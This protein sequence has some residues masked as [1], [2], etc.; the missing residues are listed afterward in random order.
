MDDELIARDA[1]CEL[2]GSCA[3]VKP[4]LVHLKREHGRALTVQQC[5]DRIAMDSHVWLAEHNAPGSKVVSAFAAVDSP[6]G[7][8]KAKQSRGGAAAEGVEKAIADAYA[9][10][11]AAGHVSFQRGRGRAGGGGKGGR[12][13]GKDQPGHCMQH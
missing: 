8:A 1:F 13:R 4:L 6:A 7:S 10:L 9:L 12:G 5:V 11:A 2:V 3:A